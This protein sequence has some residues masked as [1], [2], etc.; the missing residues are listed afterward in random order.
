MPYSTARKAMMHMAKLRNKEKSGISLV[1]G[2]TTGL[3]RLLVDKLIANGDEVR[4]I[5]K[6]NPKDDSWDWRNLPPGVIPYAADLTMRRREDEKNLLEACKGINKVYHIAG[7]SYNSRF[8]RDELI[9]TNVIGTENLLNKCIESNKSPDSQIHFI[10]T[11]S[12][13]VYGYKRGGAPLKEDSEPK[14][15]SNY[16]ESKLM[17]EHVIQLFSEIH[18]NIT[19]TIMRLGT[20]Y[21]PGYERPSFFK[22]FRMIRDQK[23]RYIGRGTNHL[24]LIH[25]DDAANALAL[26]GKKP[27]ISANNIYNL[28]DGEPHTVLS[29]F[30]SVAKVLNVPPPHSS[31]NPTI[32]RLMRKSVNISYDE[33]EFLASDRIVDISKI[34]RDLGFRPV[35]SIA[36]D[37]MLMVEEFINYSKATESRNQV[38]NV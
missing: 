30:S 11:S 19:Y 9:E 22:A 33:Y 18:S 32:A 3:G 6:S 20:L 15:G 10:Y 13:S 31:V 1:T 23:M 8:S 4:V 5:L 29:L 21:G 16:S 7:A 2:A 27:I 36:I 26:A 28:T 25:V 34:K 17:A 37:G 12:V 35:R 38:N 14:P 24:T